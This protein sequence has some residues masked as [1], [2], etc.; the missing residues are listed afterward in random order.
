MQ[1]K[2][3]ILQIVSAKLIYVSLLSQAPGIF[4]TH[5]NNIIFLQIKHTHAV[6][7][8]SLTALLGNL[9]R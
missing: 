5:L 9:R 2:A 8:F 3:R 7:K 4:Y 1:T 6:K